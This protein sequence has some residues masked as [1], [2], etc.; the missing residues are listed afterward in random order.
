MR[1]AYDRPLTC[2][3]VNSINSVGLMFKKAVFS[4]FSNEIIFTS[5]LRVA[6]YP[7]LE[8]AST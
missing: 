2:K 4:Y 1:T 8:G 7:S 3:V 6:L 5:S